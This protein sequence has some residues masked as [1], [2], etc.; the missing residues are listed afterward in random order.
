MQAPDG[1]RVNA[2]HGFLGM[3][4]RLVSEWDPARLACA[5]D[6]DWRPRWRVELIESYKT[7]RTDEPEAE[8][9]PL[10]WAEP[11]LDEQVPVI[12]EL[13]RR[14]RVAVVGAPKFE[15][16]DVIGT[17]AHRLEGEILIVSGD[18]DLFQLVKDPD[19]KVIYPRRG[20]GNVAVVDESYIEEKYSVPGR[21]YLDYAV[22]R[23]DPS[24]GL[25]GVRGVG[26]KTAS[27]LV[28]RYGSLEEVIN[29]A[30]ADPKG[31]LGKVAM[32]LDYLDRALK[33]VAVRTDVALGELDL[34]RP[35]E[36]P[37]TQTYAYAKRY[38]LLGAVRRLV[39]AL[40]S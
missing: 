2:A 24:D 17:L 28:E 23:G 1:T 4:A 30:V 40:T 10:G 29:A 14:C 38:G 20:V 25:P 12:Y 22:L 18:R 33:V 37:D 5:T 31:A 6:E 34:T 8:A 32:S 19:V 21:A 3:L 27:S 16:E 7:H 35:R 11:G 13:L 39:A 15:A 36:P 9:G 26:E